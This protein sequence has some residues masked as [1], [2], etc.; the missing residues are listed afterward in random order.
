M[1][2]YDM[3]ELEHSNA[4][5]YSYIVKNRKSFSLSD[6]LDKYDAEELIEAIGVQKVENIIRQKK[7]ERIMK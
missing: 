7:I 1:R 4:D 6:V 3:D 2:E 5:I